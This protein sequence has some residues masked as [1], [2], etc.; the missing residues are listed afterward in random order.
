MHPLER[1]GLGERAD[2]RRAG[3]KIHRVAVVGARVDR[4]AIVEHVEDLLASADGREREAR[5]HRLGVDG[6]IG[7]K[8]EVFAGAAEREPEACDHF[9]ED[10]HC[11][12]ATAAV[13]DAREESR[14]RLAG[15]A[16]GQQGLREHGRDLPRMLGKRPLERGKI[17]P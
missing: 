6:E 10:R 8:A 7:R 14:L 2:R 3:R 12:V 13:D 1:A 11:P 15:T 9:I 5:R 17:V 4:A 16:I